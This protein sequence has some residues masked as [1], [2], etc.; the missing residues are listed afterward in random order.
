ML[1][2]KNEKTLKLSKHS[3]D[4]FIAALY[5]YVNKTMSIVPTKLSRPPT[6]NS[7]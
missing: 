2:K 5:K 7:V 4:H 3:A 6:D 1:R